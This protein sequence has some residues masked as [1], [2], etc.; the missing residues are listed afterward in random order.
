MSDEIRNRI[1][2]G[3][4]GISLPRYEIDIAKGIVEGR[5]AVEIHGHNLEVAATEETIWGASTLYSYLTEAEQVKVSSS[6]PA[7]DIPASTGAWT[8][9]IHGLDANYRLIEETVTLLNPGPATTA[10][11]FLRVF[12]V[13]VMTAGTGGKNAG[14]ISVKDNADAITLGYMPVG[15]NKCHAAIWTVPSGQRFIVLEWHG[16]E[17]AAKVSHILLYIREYGEIWKLRRDVILKD[18]YFYLPMIMPRI[19]PARADIEL[20]CTATA[21]SGIIFGGFSGYYEDVKW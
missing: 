9:L 21:G 6:V 7:T 3:F 17:L 4:P 20:R 16:G 1:L 15:E 8:V 11:S 18:N 12:C 2:R 19:V 13:E 10:L 5:T 14:I